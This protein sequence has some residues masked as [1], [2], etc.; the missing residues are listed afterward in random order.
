MVS[1]TDF[2]IYLL[3]DRGKISPQSC[4][5]VVKLIPG[6]NF[7][8]VVSNNS[9]LKTK[10][11]FYLSGTYIGTLVIPK[12][13]R[14]ELKRPIQGVDR[15]FIYCEFGTSIAQKAK[16]NADSPH[17]DELTVIFY[18]EYIPEK[19]YSDAQTVYAS[20]SASID[21]SSISVPD[22]FNHYNSLKV[23]TDY[24]GAGGGI[25][26]STKT[27]QKFF[28]TPDFVTRGKYSFTLVLRSL[29]TSRLPSIIPLSDMYKYL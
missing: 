4:D 17:S 6:E 21:G 3:S 8:I 15:C 16:L 5:C 28:E 19:K 12:F 18:P 25:L 7:S 20:S 10:A 27:N 9:Y 1:R 13:E 29:E 24:A 2:D 14:C 23:E 26:G 22:G 11:K